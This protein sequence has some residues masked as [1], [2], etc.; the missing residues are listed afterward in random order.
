MVHPLKRVTVLDNLKTYHTKCP[1]I[2][3]FSDHVAELLG[4]PVLWC[5]LGSGNLPGEIHTQ[6]GR[7]PEIR[8]DH[9]ERGDTAD[10]DVGRF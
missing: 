5:S 6:E 8:E 4:C 1:V 3:L 7:Y 2:S 10:E 9:V